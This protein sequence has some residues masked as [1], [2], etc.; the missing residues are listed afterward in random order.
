MHIPNSQLYILILQWPI[1]TVTNIVAVFDKYE[2]VKVI[3]VQ[4]LAP[5]VKVPV[6]IVPATSLI[7]T[8][9][10]VALPFA[11]MIGEYADII[12]S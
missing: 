12:M 7:V 11:E 5:V 6:V 4:E 2:F 3:V 9:L 1:L 10:P 8:A